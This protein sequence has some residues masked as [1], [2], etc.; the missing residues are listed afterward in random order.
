MDQTLVNAGFDIELLIG[1]RYIE[2]ILL[3]F[4]ETGS[5]PLQP[6]VEGVTIDIF[7]PSDVDRLY[8]PHPDAVPL[9][10]SAAA[11]D[12]ELI[13]NHPSGA[14]VRITLEVLLPNQ[15]V[16]AF[17]RFGLVSDPDPQGN[18]TNH[19]IRIEVLALEVSAGIQSV[20]DDRGISNAT[21][22]QNVKAQADRDVPLP[23]VGAGQDVEKIE[24]RQLPALDGGPIA[25]G[26]YM[27][28]RLRNANEP[29]SFM[30][31]RGDVFL[32]MN[33]LED[34][35][36][37]A[38]AVRKD[39]MKDL[40]A[41]QKFL[42][43]ELNADGE[44]HYPMR[45]D[46]FDP[47]S[48]Q[49]GK[50]FGVTIGPGIDMN[51]Q[52][53]GEISVKIRGEYF[54]ENFFDPDFTFTLT[55]VPHFEGGVVTWSHRTDLSSDLAALLSF[56]VLGFAGLI[57]Y[58]VAAEIVDDSLMTQEQRDQ[59][60][61]F[62]SSL[63]VRVPMEFVRWDPFYT[64]IHQIVARVDEWIVNDKGIAF[65]GRAAL[66]KETK[67]VDHVVIRTEVRNALFEIERLDYR[68]QDHASHTAWL[69]QA[70]VFSATDRLPFLQNAA[71]PILFGLT[72]Q[73][74]IDRIPLKKILAPLDYLPKKVHLDDHK[75]FRMMCI[76][77]R[78][79]QE[80]IT[81]LERNFRNQTRTQILNDQG[82]VLR[83]AARAALEIELGMPP[84]LEQIE[85][86]FQQKIN[87]LIAEALA[88][89]RESHEYEV[90]LEQAVSD[91][92][93]LDMAPND[94]GLLQRQ[95]ILKVLG[96]DLIER[97]NRKHRPG[98]VILYY[99]D[100]ADW[101]SRDNLLNMLKYALDHTQP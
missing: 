91:V 92:L 8:E 42:F 54:I 22:L 33:F 57:I 65:I 55:L 58:G 7:Q 56:L 59:L 62:L 38:F 53:T 10:A 32:A 18:P 86:R 27:N 19:R 78:E 95:G 84:T 74:I 45:R 99:R 64:T 41:H 28:L 68:V 49:I 89:Y 31:E 16:T 85:A 43:A 3:S 67:P 13:F 40:S 47:T 34:G 4:T 35:R 46:M 79:I 82:S 39:F 88:A 97:H 94:Y 11:F 24:M 9:T 25:I 5:F 77:P 48:E 73:Q 15:F 61:T 81:L 37:I 66:G 17:A 29:T 101:D 20:L 6:V 14:N 71:E 70:R 90:E 2:Y 51:G 80:Q 60:T 69:N 63:P 26:F 50:L 36:D 30:P 1:S 98:T 21:L 12:A 96:Y 76:T 83:E 52:F 44:Y 93:R 23:F 87:A 72:A 75:I 100:R